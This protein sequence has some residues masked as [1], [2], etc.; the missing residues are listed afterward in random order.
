VPKNS[1]AP[2]VDS[3]LAF[4]STLLPPVLQPS[5][6]T[7]NTGPDKKQHLAAV[8]DLFEKL[9]KDMMYQYNKYI[10]SCSYIGVSCKNTPH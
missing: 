5:V 1:G 4:E 7:G 10:P 2:A 9:E 6:E 3:S 8:L